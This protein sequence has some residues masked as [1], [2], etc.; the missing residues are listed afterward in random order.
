MMLYMKEKEKTTHWIES[1]FLIIIIIIILYKMTLDIILSL[2]LYT[3]NVLVVNIVDKTKKKLLT[4]IF[5]TYKKLKNKRMIYNI[6][7]ITITFD[8]SNSS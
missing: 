4:L 1:W 8:S 6:Q 5:S 3:F 2:S 7:S